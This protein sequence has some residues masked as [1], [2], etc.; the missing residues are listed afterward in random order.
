MMREEEPASWHAIHGGV[1]LAI[2]LLARVSLPALAWPWFWVIPLAAY[3]IVV[4]AVPRLRRTFPRPRGGM[5]NCLSVAVTVAGTVLSCGV[6]VGYQ[7]LFRPEVA[8]LA[9][10]LPV[11][12]FGSLVLAGICF[13]I[14]NAVFEEVVF[15]GVLYDALK[16]EWGTVVA[17]LVTAGAFGL[18]HL[19]GYPPGLLGAV[20][21]GIY[22]AMLGLLRWWTGGLLL[23]IA[24]HVCADATIFSILVAA[25][26][27]ATTGV[28]NSV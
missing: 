6:L 26:A 10:G 24:S 18:G 20:L 17:V 3:A 27:F 28:S 25:G 2:L 23:P 7:V 15:R 13:S 4:L 16:A 14:G 12:A 5:I 8:S 22:G 11:A 21:A 9:R 19:Q 1:F